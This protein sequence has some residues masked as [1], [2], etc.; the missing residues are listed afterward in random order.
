MFKSFVVYIL[1]YRKSS[2]SLEDENN[3]TVF[4]Y[5]SGLLRKFYSIDIFQKVERITVTVCRIEEIF[6]QQLS[7]VLMSG[8]YY[9][10]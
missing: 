2:L 6:S 3:F 1:T 4:S 7:I 5:S 10:A 8:L 9:V